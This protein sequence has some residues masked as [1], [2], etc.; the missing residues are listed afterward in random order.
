M[1]KKSKP[2]K[3]YSDFITKVEK[4]INNKNHLV[5]WDIESEMLPNNCDTFI[6]RDYNSEIEIQ[7]M[8]DIKAYRMFPLIKESEFEIRYMTNGY[9]CA[10]ELPE[11]E[12]LYLF[13][14]RI[15]AAIKETKQ[16]F[17]ESSDFK[18]YQF[19]TTDKEMFDLIELMQKDKE[20]KK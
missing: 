17:A 20:K 18:N 9:I 2:I 7:I 6:F 8:P 14:G 16:A 11:L 1:F 12:N 5:L 13:V 4:C 15:I 3:E 10:T 19:I